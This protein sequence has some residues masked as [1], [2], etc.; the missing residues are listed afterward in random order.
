M[1]ISSKFS[2]CTVKGRLL[3]MFSSVCLGTTSHLVGNSVLVDTNTFKSLNFFL[4]VKFKV[5]LPSAKTASGSPPI[6]RQPSRSHVMICG[7]RAAS[8]LSRR[9]RYATGGLRSI[10]QRPEST[11]ERMQE[12]AGTHDARTHVRSSSA[13]HTLHPGGLDNPMTRLTSSVPLPVSDVG[14]AERVRACV[15][16][17]VGGVSP[18][19]SNTNIM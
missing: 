8:E 13:T 18:S 4:T 15:C 12:H 6:R 7:T 11:H 14:L 17:W 10:I 9:S 1:F 2:R 16:V 3:S 5:R 19:S